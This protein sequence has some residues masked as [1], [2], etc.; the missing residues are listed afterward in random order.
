[1][2]VDPQPS[3]DLHATKIKTPPVQRFFEEPKKMAC[4]RTTDSILGRDN[5]LIVAFA[6]SMIGAN[7]VEAPGVMECWSV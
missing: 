6:P 5:N 3:G 7:G 2:L 4:L 1:M